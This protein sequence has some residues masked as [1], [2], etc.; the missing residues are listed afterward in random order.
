VY[1]TGLRTIPARV[2]DNPNMASVKTRAYAALA[3]SL[4][5]TRPDAQIDAKGYVADVRQNLLAGLDPAAIALALADIGLGAGQ[6]L[7]GKIRAAHSSAMLAVNTFAPWR[8]DPAGM[9][10]HPAAQLIHFERKLSMGLKG[11]PPHLDLVV[12]SAERI[13][14]VESKCTEHLSLHEAWFAPSVVARMQKIGHPSWDARLGDVRAD[15]VRRRLDRAQLLKH[16]LG[17]KNNFPSQPA[18]LLYLFWEPL[19]WGEFAECVDHRSEVSA[20]ATGLAD[21][22]VDFQARSYADLWAEWDGD[23]RSRLA[24]RYLFEI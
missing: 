5:R 22:L 8:A 14:A 16:Y 15:P 17:V 6:E 11:Q 1:S 24:D 7:E 10:L 2:C 21:P 20:F 4:I 3:K 13:V 23:H 18:T 12:E 19:N 9:P